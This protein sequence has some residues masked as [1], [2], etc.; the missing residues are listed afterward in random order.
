MYTVIVTSLDIA[1]ELN[2]VSDVIVSAIPVAV[3]GVPFF[4]NTTEWYPPIDVVL[5]QTEVPL[6][7]AVFISTSVP[8]YWL[9]PSTL[10]TK[11]VPIP[12]SLVTKYAAIDCTLLIFPEASLAQI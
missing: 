2:I 1:D 9:V 12:S 7:T 6:R 8:V 11:S 5:T 3:I 4:L 10:V